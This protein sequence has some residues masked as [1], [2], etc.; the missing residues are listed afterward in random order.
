VF[1]FLHRNRNVA[2]AAWLL[3]S[4]LLAVAGAG[5]LPRTAASCAN[6]T[7]A[8]VQAAVPVEDNNPDS[9]LRL[10]YFRIAADALRRA[11]VP[12]RTV[13]DQDVCAG[14]LDGCT[15][16][17]F[18]YVYEWSRELEAATLRYLR[19]GG[20]VI[21]CYR[22]PA[23]VARALGVR[24]QGVACDDVGH[25]FDRCALI[26]I[27]LPGAPPSFVQ[28]SWHVVLA[29]PLGPDAQ[30]LY[31]WRN[32]RE[33]PTGHPAVILSSHGAYLGHVLTKTD[34]EAKAAL[35]MSLLGHFCPD[36]WHRCAYQALTDVGRV[37]TAQSLGDLRSMVEEAAEE[38]RAKGALDFMD[39]VDALVDRARDDISHGRYARAISRAMR[40]HKLASYAYV[41]TLP[42][43]DCELRGLWVNNP[44]GIKG[45]G[46]DWTARL[47]ARMGFNAVF[48]NMGSAVQAN[49]PSA[50]LPTSPAAQGTDPLAECL[51]AC[52]ENGLECHAWRFAFFAGNMPPETFARLRDEGRLQVDRSGKVLPWL[53]PSDPRNTELERRVLLELASRY[54][55]QG[56]HLDYVRFANAN[57]CF[58]PRCRR[59]F[60]GALGRTYRWW[61]EQL[62]NGPEYEQF[63]RW[64]QGVISGFVKQVSE[65][66]HA[67]KPLL[68]VSAAVVPTLK[69]EGYLV[70]QRWDQWVQEDW[71]NF[72]CPMD[73]GESADNVEGLVAQQVRVT[74]G[75]IPL[76]AGLGSWLLQD[77]TD[78][79]EQIRASRESGADGYVLFHGDDLTLAE[80]WLPQ[81]RSGP[82]TI[83][84]VAPHVGP[85]SGLAYPS[86]TR[87]DPA[88]GW[89]LARRDEPF[90]IAGWVAPDTGIRSA[91]LALTYLD[92]KQ[93][94]RSYR[95]TPGRRREVTF[96]P[97]PGTYRPVITGQ[98]GQRPF[99]RRGRIIRVLS[100]GDR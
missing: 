22:I 30:T 88:S 35:L 43:R 26:G 54:D 55:L 95:L 32:V 79:A 85:W 67:K 82:T 78:L 19:G 77:V 23:S 12:F 66:L 21:A 8:L 16:A 84:A 29:E 94:G 10:Q 28:H 65:E 75:G 4:A 41:R 44:R 3:A 69:I 76:Y 45:S 59:A 96:S 36:L 27:G 74:G 11:G 81:L 73:Y 14:A 98:W 56:I 60:E 100:P 62:V 47:L 51:K 93:V 5:C 91:R 86:G 97:P 46:W 37:G 42:T 83:N 64:R 72:V 50:I 34:R 61:P 20:K 58:C 17:V 70:A 99:E 90:T 89:L 24:L 40:A 39:E 2:L 52:R 68:E 15:V 63:Q 1:S 6:S 53:C 25:P 92:G 49:Y 9:K 7:V 71:L 87:P 57:T 18:P 33:Q 80:D 31:E 48:V 38:G 13:S